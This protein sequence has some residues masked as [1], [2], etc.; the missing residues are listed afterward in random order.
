MALNQTNDFLRFSAYSIKDLITRKLSEDSNFTDQIYEGSNLAILI[1]IVSYMYQCLIYNLN[2]SAAES[3]FSDTQLYENIVRL[4]K[5]IGYHPQGFKPAQINGYI[6]NSEAL[7]QKQIY[8][9]SAFDTGLF[10]SQGNKIYFSTTFSYKNDFQPVAINDDAYTNVMLM[11]GKWKKYATIFTASG[12]D[13]ETFILDGIRSD[14]STNEYVAN[15]KIQVFI[16]DSD[17][18]VERWDCDQNEIFVQAYD[19]AAFGDVGNGTIFS[20]LYNEDSRVYTAYLNE[21]KTYEI[22]FGNNISGRRLNAGDR[23]HVLYLDTNG[24]DGYIDASQIELVQENAVF[25]HSPGFFGID[26]TLYNKMF[27]LVKGGELDDNIAGNDQKG[28]DPYRFTLKLDIGS[29]TTTQ[30]EENV[31]DVRNNA[32]SW[33]KTG[34]RLITKQDYEYFIKSNRNDMFTGIIDVVCMNNWDYMT[35]L[36][37][38]LY[39][40]GMN[41]CKY[42]TEEVEAN[43][44]RYLQRARLIQSGYQYVDAADANN[45]YLW[46]ATSNE[47]DILKL[48]A[49]LN[50]QI[51]QIKTMTSETY[52][53]APVEVYFDISF[54]PEQMFY[55]SLVEKKNS[56]DDA[57]K[58]YLEVTVAD[59]SI[60]STTSILNS[61]AQIIQ[62]TFAAQNCRLGQAINY[63]DILNHIY[64]LNGVER[65]RTVYYPDDYLDNSSNYTEYKTRACDGIA[66]ASWSNTDLIELG[67][68]LEITNSIRTL[69][70]FQFPKLSPSLELKNKIKIIKKQMNTTGPIKF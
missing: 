35:T 60:Y 33:F 49:D 38:W 57:N 64:A 45:I 53:L 46:I 51:A 43:P 9:C 25:Q 56:S 69:E 70:K 19:S 32:P 18:N 41:P 30:N 59:N 36:Y 34:N 65:I 7:K 3:M 67:D 12:V 50:N 40:F 37:K 39:N 5:F 62:G 20:K 52:P 68:D 22:K 14:S 54:T 13:Y 11:N 16:E 63:D 28:I 47:S 2:S 15:A 58:S 44:Y 4:C 31:E 24:P 27:S 55:E 23:I 8:P 21:N 42:Y 26:E 66:F 6:E 48:K 61:I 1:D 10:D 29:L 17:G